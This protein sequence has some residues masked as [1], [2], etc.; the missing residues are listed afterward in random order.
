MLNGY[1]ITK[2]KDAQLA[3]VHSKVKE[4]QAEL[5]QVKLI[6]QQVQTIIAKS[7]LMRK[8]LAERI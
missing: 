1:Q 2:E 7:T 4:S 8:E 5:D 3:D 6:A